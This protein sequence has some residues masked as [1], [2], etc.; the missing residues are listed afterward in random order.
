V[1]KAPPPPDVRQRV[2]DAVRR[3]PGIHLREIE[4]QTGISAPLAQYHLR[5]LADD[6]FVE[7][8]EQGG[9]ARYY[10]TAK[11]KSARVT[12]ADM[13]LVGLLREEV[14]LHVALLLLDRGPMT[15]TEIVEAAGVAK[16]TVSYHLA[17]LAEAGIVERVSN[18][19]RLHLAD[20]ER[21]YRL[22]LAYRPTPGLLDTFAD[23]WGDLY[24]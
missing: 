15:H 5:K 6:G 4:R 16:S 22:L 7:H 18:D 13:P 14:P 21:V 17:K 1:A 11:G 12:E 8:H 3:Y 19:T 23:L 2:Y 9:Y 20:R 10:P 24:G